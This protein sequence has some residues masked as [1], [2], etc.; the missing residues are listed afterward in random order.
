MWWHAWLDN[1]KSVSPR[2]RTPLADRYVVVEHGRAIDHFGAAELDAK[3]A[4]LTEQL[5][6]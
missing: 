1:L 2:R 6:V 5:G 3:M 4:S